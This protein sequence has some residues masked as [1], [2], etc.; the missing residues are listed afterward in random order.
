[1]PDEQEPIQPEIVTDPGEFTAGSFTPAMDSPVLSLKDRLKSQ[2]SDSQDTRQVLQGIKRGPGRPKG[3]TSS[4]K[5]EE[6]KSTADTV[7]KERKAKKQRSDEIADQIV[8]DLNDNMMRLILAQGVPP[9]LVYNKGYMPVSVNNN[10]DKYTPFG[11]KLVIDDFTAK[12]VGS[13]IAEFEQSDT[14]MEIV[15]KATGGTVALVI[16]GLLA[17]VCVYGYVNG[18]RQALNDPQMQQLMQGYRDYQKNKDQN[19][20]QEGNNNG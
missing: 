15:G 3:S 9:F 7:L 20:R 5:P 6:P 11:Q 13:F 12:A 8:T 14:G 2:S 1:M 4:R 10:T 16:K 17:G 19:N 18:I